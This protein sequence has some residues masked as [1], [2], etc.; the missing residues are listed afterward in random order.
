MICHGNP[1]ILNITIEVRSLAWPGRSLTSKNEDCIE[2]EAPPI[3]TYILKNNYFEKKKTTTKTVHYCEDT[4]GRICVGR[5]VSRGQCWQDQI[6]DAVQCYSACLHC[7]AQCTLH[8]THCSDCTACRCGPSLRP[9]QL[10]ALAGPGHKMHLL[11]PAGRLPRPWR[12][13]E[14]G[15]ELDTPQ[16]DDLQVRP[17]PPHSPPP[18]LFILPP[19]QTW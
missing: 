13:Q 9:Q 16:G 1:V 11:A 19:L 8:T 15:G 10:Y 4:V 12:R 14:A 2:I 5:I 18:H 17:P 6:I 3:K 7:S